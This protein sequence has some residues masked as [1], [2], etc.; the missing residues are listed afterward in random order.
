MLELY[1]E[2]AEGRYRTLFETGTGGG[3]TDQDLRRGWERRMFGDAYDGHDVQRPKYG[4]VNFLVHVQVGDPLPPFRNK[5]HRGQG[6]EE[7]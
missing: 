3:S 4:S 5:A 1:C 6:P 2:D 7:E